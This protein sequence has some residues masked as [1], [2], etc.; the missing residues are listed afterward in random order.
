LQQCLRGKRPCSSPGL[1]SLHGVSEANRILIFLSHSC[2]PG[3]IGHAL[4][5]D[6]HSRGLH[7]IATARDREK[8]KDLEILGLTTLSLEVTSLESILA[9][10]EVV[11]GLAGGGLDILVNNA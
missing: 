6:F 4:A 10:K 3:G 1:F 9:A 8:I 11:S 2:T 7:V 5:R